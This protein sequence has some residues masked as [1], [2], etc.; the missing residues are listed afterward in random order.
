MEGAKEMIAD[1]KKAYRADPFPKATRNTE[2]P[3]QIFKS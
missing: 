1:N 3:K 2:Q